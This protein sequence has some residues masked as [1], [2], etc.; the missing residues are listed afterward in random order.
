MT[1]NVSDLLVKATTKCK[2]GFACL[3]DKFDSMCGV[4]A[5]DKGHT[6]VIKPHIQKKPCEYL[7]NRVGGDANIAPRRP[8]LSHAVGTLFAG[9]SGERSDWAPRLQGK[10]V[11]LS[12][13]G[14]GTRAGFG[15]FPSGVDIQHSQRFQRERASI[16]FQV[17][18]VLATP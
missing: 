17:S 18:P 4:E 9:A 10:G 13:G 7:Q 11:L 16:P 2:K 14:R 12:Y 1:P 6:I 8:S 15:I 5:T 3:S